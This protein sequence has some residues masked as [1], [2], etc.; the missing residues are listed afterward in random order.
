MGRTAHIWRSFSKLASA[1]ELDDRT[2]DYRQ[3]AVESQNRIS[4]STTKKA[5]HSW[6]SFRGTTYLTYYVQ[7][8]T[9]LLYK[10]QRNCVLL[11][12]TLAT[13]CQH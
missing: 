13:D 1:S 10:F 7:S 9:K 3:Q 2:C 11:E 12:N 6:D 4:R 8:A 5:P